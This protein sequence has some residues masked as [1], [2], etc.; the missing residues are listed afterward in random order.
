[1]TDLL[2]KAMIEGGL[3][4]VAALG[5]AAWFWERRRHLDTT[6]ALRELSV[7]Q[8]EAT[9]KTEAAINM[10]TRVMESFLGKD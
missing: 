2:I 1:M 7:A 9:T 3:Y 4:A 6:E 5:W 10:N 8:I